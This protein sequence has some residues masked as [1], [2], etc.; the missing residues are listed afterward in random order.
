MYLL[1][2][3]FLKQSCWGQLPLPPRPSP[4]NLLLLSQFT[5]SCSGQFPAQQQLPTS[6]RG[7]PLLVQ[8]EFDICS[9]CVLWG[10]W[11]TQE[12]SNLRGSPQSMRERSQWINTQLRNPLP[13][14]PHSGPIL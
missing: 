5:G 3:F 1:I 10:A 4:S 7:H 13:P 6:R 12:L 9:V 11:K 14:N 2:S 8:K